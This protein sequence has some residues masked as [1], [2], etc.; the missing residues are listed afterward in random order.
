MIKKDEKKRLQDEL[1]VELDKVARFTYGDERVDKVHADA[2][3]A[4]K[5]FFE[6]NPEARKH[7]GER[8][9]KR[10]WAEHEA[11][12]KGLSAPTPEA[13]AVREPEA[14]PSL[15]RAAA[16]ILKILFSMEQTMTTKDIFSALDK[17]QDALGCAIGERAVKGHV[18]N[19]KKQGL[20]EH[21]F[22]RKGGYSITAKGKSLI[23]PAE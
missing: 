4:G 17:Y 7:V 18:G 5:N 1:E 22:G 19:L 3:E 14:E 8:E 20:I 10:L 16:A 9:I 6:N 13:P 23:S 21:P 15:H 12:S 11:K 2:L